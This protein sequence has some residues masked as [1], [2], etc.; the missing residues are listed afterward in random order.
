MKFFK[1]TKPNQTTESQYDLDS[2]SKLSITEQDQLTD[3][4]S[5]YNYSNL[6]YL[7]YNNGNSMSKLEKVVEILNELEINFLELQ[8]GVILFNPPTSPLYETLPMTS[9]INIEDHTLLVFN[10]ELYKGEVMTLEEILQI[11]STI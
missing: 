11:A 2:F 8:K 9:E 3:I 6:A 7:H 10:E 4:E 5:F 1:K